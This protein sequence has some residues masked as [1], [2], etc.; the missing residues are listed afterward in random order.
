M[1]GE[2]EETFS[3]RIRDV[4]HAIGS[5]LPRDYIE[6]LKNGV[7]KYN[8][9]PVV[10][11]R[12]D[13]WDIL[14]FFELGGGP[15]YVQLDEMCRLVSDVLPRFAVPIAS[16]QAGNLFCLFV[17]GPH[18]GQVVW[19]D[20]ERASNDYEIEVVSPSLSAFLSSIQQAS[21]DSEPGLRN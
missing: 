16:D 20:H 15:K 1:K 4:E 11:F 18:S 17:D 8:V 13:V 7:P 12:D 9:P 10:P 5:T 6:L 3:N 19:W 2:P 21:G 14:D